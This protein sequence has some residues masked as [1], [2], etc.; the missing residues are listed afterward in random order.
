MPV[1]SHG[2]TCQQFPLMLF[3]L[4]LLLSSVFLSV[5]SYTALHCY[6]LLLLIYFFS[7]KLK[8]L[9]QAQFLLVTMFLPW[10]SSHCLLIPRGT[11]LPLFVCTVGRWGADPPR[12]PSRELVDECTYPVTQYTCESACHSHTS[13]LIS[14][15]RKR[16]KCTL[17]NDN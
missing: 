15:S 4:K 12:K 16:N 10:N 6:V 3:F 7:L 8:F 1:I 5:L 9:H 14:K 11:D 17:N 2:L 13:F